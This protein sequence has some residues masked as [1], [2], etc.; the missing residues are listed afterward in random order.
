MAQILLLEGGKKL[1]VDHTFADGGASP[2]YAM[3]GGQRTLL[4]SGSPP[5]PTVHC[6]MTSTK[7]AIFFFED[8]SP[9]EKPEDVSGLPERFKAMALR[10]L[11]TD[12]R[13]KADPTK[14]RP[15]KKEPKRKIALKAT[16]ALGR[17]ALH[18]ARV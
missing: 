17:E 2:T 6:R 5:R 3:V 12:G 18:P 14:V 11:E 15:R 9:I 13:R 4:D 7:E 10:F 8:G 1:D 16:E